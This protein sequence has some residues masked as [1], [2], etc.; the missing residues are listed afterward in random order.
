LQIVR[1]LGVTANVQGSASGTTD[2]VVMMELDN[3]REAFR[4]ELWL[5]T[6]RVIT[7]RKVENSMADKSEKASKEEGKAD[8][9]DKAEIANNPLPGERADVTWSQLAETMIAGWEADQWHAVG[10]A[11]CDQQLLVSIDNQVIE[12]AY[13]VVRERAGSEVAAGITL[14]TSRCCAIG[15]RSGG[16]EVRELKIWRDRH[17]LHPAADGR[18]WKSSQPLGKD[19]Y[20]VM[21]DNPAVSVDSRHWPARSVTVGTI[22]GVVAEGERR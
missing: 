10:V 5:G 4:V 7:W 18:D 16:V 13:E 19:E 1:D 12:Q 20:F 3:G 11:L 15:A 6:G 22:R 8:K 14:S 17:W 9:G 2:A 21:G